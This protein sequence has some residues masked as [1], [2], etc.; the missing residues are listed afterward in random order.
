[1][2]KPAMSIAARWLKRRVLEM[3]AVDRILV[4]GRAPSIAG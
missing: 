4:R 2:V 3:V 1:M